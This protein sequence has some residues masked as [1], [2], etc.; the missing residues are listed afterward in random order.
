MK[1]KNAD[2]PTMKWTSVKKVFSFMSESE[3]LYFFQ[4]HKINIIIII[5]TKY[6]RFV[7]VV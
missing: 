2:K 6:T 5:I 7:C 4:F 1:N 3:L